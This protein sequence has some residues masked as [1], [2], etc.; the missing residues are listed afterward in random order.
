MNPQQERLSTELGAK[1]GTTSSH[2]ETHAGE[3]QRE[4]SKDTS[5]TEHRKEWQ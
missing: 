1:T 3:D 4:N 5:S 2:A